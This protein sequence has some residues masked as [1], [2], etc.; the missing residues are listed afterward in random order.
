MLH[1]DEFA[2]TGSKDPPLA[3][4]SIP[5]LHAVIELILEPTSSFEYIPTI[6][7]RAFRT[8]VREVNTVLIQEGL[9]WCR[10]SLGNVL[11]NRTRDLLV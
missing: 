6:K 3:G 1:E 10:R 2:R 5:S 4:Y 9:H 8:Y 7:Q 11:S